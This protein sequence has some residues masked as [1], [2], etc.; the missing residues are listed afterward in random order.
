R[1]MVIVGDH[2]VTADILI[3]DDVTMNLRMLMQICATGGYKVHGAETGASAVSMATSILP[4][5][6]L[7]DVMLPD[8]DGYEVAARIKS[9]PDTSD[10]PIIFISA[11]SDMDSKVKALGV[12]GVDY[13][14]KPI[15][16]EEILARIETHLRI[17]NLHVQLQEQLE[18]KEALIHR[19]NDINDQLQ[20]EVEERKQ[21]ERRLES[22]LSLLKA[23]LQRTRAM[24]QIARS[25]IGEETLDDILSIV[26]NNL[27]K[28]LPADRVIVALLTHDKHDFESY[29]IEGPGAEFETVPPFEQYMSGLNGWVIEKVQPVIS[30]KGLP[31]PRESA[32]EQ[33]ER[34]K[35]QRGSVVVVPLYYRG[36]ILGTIMAINSPAEWDFNQIHLD[37]IAAIAS[38]AAVAITTLR[39][40]TETAYLKQ[41]NESIVREVGDAILVTNMDLRIR[42]ANPA[43]V[44]M[45]GYTDKEL[46][47][48]DLPVI[49][50]DPGLVSPFALAD[51][52]YKSIETKLLT[53]Q[54]DE[55]FVLFSAQPIQDQDTS[56]GLLATFTD[57]SEM[58]ASAAV[59][60]RYASDLET[61]NA[62]LNA[63]AHTVAHD[64]KN[65]LTSMIGFS[66]ILMDHRDELPDHLVGQHIDYIFRSAQTMNNIIRELLLLASVREKDEIPIS[67]LSM[68]EIVFEVL[69]RLDYLV[70][71]SG[72]GIQIPSS[73]PTAMG[74]APWIEEVWTNYISNGLKYGGDPEQGVKPQLI[75]GAEVIPPNEESQIPLVHFWVRDNGSGL[76]EKEMAQLFT[77]FER[78]HNVR[79]EGHGLGLSIVQ[80]IV[81]K[82]DGKVD[83]H[84]E[85]GVGS[86]FGFTLPGY[87]ESVMIVY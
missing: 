51:V 21:A 26:A 52:R 24:N 5:L 10:I 31:D 87:H 2:P 8:F 18:E 43:A 66:T 80:R 61:Q 11:R 38:Q 33:A 1:E 63:F 73:W 79:T 85:V 55:V 46:N 3:V 13:V 9:N 34:M 37:L 42:F 77:P 35:C 67:E 15:R 84:S 64:L 29:V 76:T 68:E 6:I 7:L 4:D 28:A 70:D 16:M 50:A 41:F 25:L 72:A 69:Q 23:T 19:L 62:E 74:Y 83:F 57:I 45:L 20:N 58:K 81:E 49:L 86:V 22:T 54:G 27:S 60:E 78:L 40:A 75:L 53:K 17:R 48:L 12:G 30:P 44:S 82:L 65:P 59:L 56:T 36:V 39:L 47:T 71:E 32:T 14:T